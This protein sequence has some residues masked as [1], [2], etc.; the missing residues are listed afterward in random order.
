MKD[1]EYASFVQSRLKSGEEILKQMTSEKANANHMITLLNEEA[2]ELT[3]PIKKWI[4]Y[5]ADIDMENVIEEIG[6]CYFALSALC[7]AFSITESECKEENVK[8]LS[9]RYETVY[10]DKSAKIRL[11]KKQSNPESD[12]YV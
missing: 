1:E 3:S 4:F 9:R 2:G 8:K 10:S 12:P 5:G 11:D 6:D 7:S